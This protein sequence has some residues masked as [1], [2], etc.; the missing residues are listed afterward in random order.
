[1]KA[2]QSEYD[3]KIQINYDECE[4]RLVCPEN[5]VLLNGGLC[6]WFWDENDYDN[7]RSSRS[8]KFT[9][10]PNVTFD[11]N[12]IEYLIIPRKMEIPNFI[13]KLM[14]LKTICHKEITEEERYLLVSKVISIEQI[15]RDF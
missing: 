8:D 3:G 7:W 9:D 11:V 6:T 13:K 12:D 1:M 2:Y 5:K 14:D 10:I 15:K 4:W